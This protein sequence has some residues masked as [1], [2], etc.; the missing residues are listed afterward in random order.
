M[1]FDPQIGKVV[2]FGGEGPVVISGV[3]GDTFFNETWTFDGSNW[4]QLSPAT[5][6][7]ARDDAAIAY[8]PSIGKVVLFGGFGTGDAATWTFDGS[9]WTQLSPAVSPPWR[10]GASMEYDPSIDRIVLFGGYVGP[11]SPGDSKETWTFDGTTWTQLAPLPSPP[12]RQ[13]ASMVYD[14]SIDRVLLFGG[15]TGARES[16]R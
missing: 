2:L 16:R 4:N 14:P 15:Y 6:P 8:D 13:S 11:G 5:S 7:S 12:A 9:T 3:F 10:G 1:V